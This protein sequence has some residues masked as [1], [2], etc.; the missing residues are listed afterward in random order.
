MESL[1]TETVPPQDSVEEEVDD[2]YFH[3]S[4]TVGN[5]EMGQ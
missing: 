1:Q 5:K 2:Y 3:D 4:T